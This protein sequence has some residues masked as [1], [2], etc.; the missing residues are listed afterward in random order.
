MTIQDRMK[1]RRKRRIP[2][3]EAAVTGAIV[4]LLFIFIAPRC[5]KPPEK[6]VIDYSTNARTPELDQA[7]QT[8]SQQGYAIEN[9]Y[10]IY[11]RL[12]KARIPGDE[13]SEAMR[14]AKFIKAA[15]GEAVEVQLDFDGGRYFAHPDKGI[16]V[17]VI[18]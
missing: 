3:V 17:P 13:R 5:E 10:P 9:H 1:H 18:R 12:Y 8:L 4:G 14:I 15:T 16:I 11:I 7:L 2:F 6:L